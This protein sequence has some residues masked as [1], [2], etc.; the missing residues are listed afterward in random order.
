MH[1][2]LTVTLTISHDLQCFP[3]VPAGLAPH[4]ICSRS[5]VSC[6]LKYVY[7]TWHLE[8]DSHRSNFFFFFFDICKDLDPSCWI[9]IHIH[10]CMSW[11][12]LALQQPWT[13]FFCHEFFPLQNSFYSI[14]PV[15]ILH[16]NLPICLNVI[17]DNHFPVQQAVL[18]KNVPSC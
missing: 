9:L 18:G 17:C 15:L 8:M 4:G 11:P 12:L 3:E 5:G 16:F 7:F 10:E 1:L 13:F 2:L 14:I 6:Y